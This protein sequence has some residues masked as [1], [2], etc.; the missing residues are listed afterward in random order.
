MLLDLVPTRRGKKRMGKIYMCYIVTLDVTNQ[1]T[2]YSKLTFFFLP[3]EGDKIRV[4]YCL[5]WLISVY[6]LLG[7]L[8]FKNLPLL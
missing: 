4:S 5:N 3:L 8:S 2:K 6:L 7:W 1:R